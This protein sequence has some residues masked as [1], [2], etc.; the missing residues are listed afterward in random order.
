MSGCQFGLKTSHL[1]ALQIAT[2]IIRCIMLKQVNLI[3]HMKVSGSPAGT[4]DDTAICHH[5]S[6]ILTFLLLISIISSQ[7]VHHLAITFCHFNDQSLHTHTHQKSRDHNTHKIKRKFLNPQSDFWKL[8]HQPVICFYSITTSPQTVPTHPFFCPKPHVY[9]KS[10][11][12][13]SVGDTKQTSTHRQYKIVSGNS[14]STLVLY[15][16]SVFAG[17]FFSFWQRL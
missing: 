5:Q 11:Q 14:I 12:I 9:V 10:R 13:C 16:I 3:C 15:S 8:Q 17:V 6:H 2:P 7:H 4:I 1:S